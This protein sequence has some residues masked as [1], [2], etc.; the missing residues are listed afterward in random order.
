MD[1]N[2]DEAARA[3]EIAEKKFSLR[4][5]AGAKKFALKALN[6]YPALEGVP[7]FLSIL[8]VYISA[9]NK[10]NGQMDWYGILGVDPF[11][12]EET[13]RKK[14]RVLALSLHPDKN[15]SLGAEGAFKLVSEAWSLLSDKAKRLAYNN[16]RSVGG[17]QHNAPN[18]V[19]AQSKA[20]SSNGSNNPK[21]NATSNVGG[22]Q[23]NAPN[24]VGAQS[25]APSSSG[26][27]N[28][29]KNATSDGRTGNNNARAPPSP[30]IPRPHKMS[31]TFW[32]SCS[33][34]KVH[35]EYLRVYLDQILLCPNCKEAFKAIEKSP[36]P[37]AVKS[38]NSASRKH[39]QK[40][41]HHAGKNHPINPGRTSAVSQDKKSSS[42]AGMSSFNNTSFQRGPPSRMPGFVGADGSSSVTAASKQHSSKKRKFE[43]AASITSREKNHPINLG[44][45]SAVSQDKKSSSSAGM[46]SFNNTSFQ[47]GP[48]S[49]MPGFLGADGSSS[50]T[51]A[52]F[53]KQSGEKRRKFEGAASIAAREK[54]NMYKASDGSFSN[55]ETP[56]EKIRIDDIHLYRANHM[57]M[58]D[59]A[60][61]LGSGKP[62]MGTERT[63]GFP[64]VAIKHH[65]RELSL[66]ETR[67]MLINKAQFEIRKKLQEW[68]SAAQAKARKNDKG[69]IRQKSTFD[70]KT[71]GPEKHGG[72]NFDSNNYM[73]CDSIGES[74]KKK[75]AYVAI[76][77]PDP[78]FHNF[79]LDRSEN[80][81]EEDQVWAAYDDDDG[82]PRF[83]AR[84]HKVI[85]AKPFRIQISW[86]N[87][88]SNSEL[89]PMNWVGSGFYKTCGDFRL[90]RHEITESLNSFSHKVRWTKGRGVFRIFPGKGEIWAL[91]KNWSLDWNENTPDEVVHKYDMV[92]VLQDFSEEEGVLVAPLVKV[93][94]F[95]TVFRRHSHGQV[96]KIPK[97]EMFCFSHQVPSYSLTGQESH[98]APK[99]CRELD[100]AAT[101]LDL[102]Q[103]T[104]EADEALDNVGKSKE[105][106][107]PSS[108][109]KCVC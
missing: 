70:E 30:S 45:T 38:S 79:D 27:N 29:K 6:L 53:K 67:T 108:S 65:M 3:K 101:P 91:Y 102:L 11:A 94:G 49:R 25:K 42:S 72:S 48:P 7:Q 39:D 24:H 16:I 69:H 63:Y 12:D 92:E 78:D 1:C 61:S 32:S 10:I 95:K 98:N 73:K 106:K 35:F 84:I 97:V 17:L 85:S 20:P 21:K 59:G 52:S 81:F 75:Q 34:C 14:Y 62:N 18:H 2:K 8:N 26:S 68:R 96:R 47:R 82:M 104:T 107:M 100:P 31:G 109:E 56:M 51:A 22:P 60:T 89:G 28:P 40:S 9:E 41:Q 19:G 86:L 64:G 80:S 43:G 87:S 71:T 46:P 90:G 33:R 37:N 50:V 55:V 58:R 76:S 105:D 44:R 103:A 23:H 83:Y 36:P 54:N 88:R 13:I 57:T 77:V 5:Y 74:V 99:G 66:F 4:E 93:N 15:R